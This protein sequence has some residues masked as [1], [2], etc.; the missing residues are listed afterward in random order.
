[1][2]QKFRGGA[3]GTG[4]SCGVDSFDAIYMHYNTEFLSHNLTHLCINNVGAFANCYHEYGQDKVKDERYKKAQ[5]LADELGLPLIKT[6]SNFMESFEQD[7]IK[8]HTF[9]SIFAVYMLKKLWKTYYYGSSGY[10]YTSFSLKNIEDIDSA[11]YELLS[12]QCLSL[13]ELK[14]YSEGGEKT[15][16]EKVQDIVNFPYTERYL[17]VCFLKPYNCGQCSKCRRTLVALDAL[18]KLENYKE[19]FDISYYKTHKGEYYSWLASLH[20][21]NDEFAEPVYKV[22]L[23]RDEFLKYVRKEKVKKVMRG[24]RDILKKR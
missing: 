16:F 19:V 3:V 8:T 23:E 18:N 5:E 10:D 11:Q 17:H 15:R 24:L 20:S 9:S 2:L 6:D 13:R 7:H 12:L 21:Y 14:I 22:M 4:C 1:M